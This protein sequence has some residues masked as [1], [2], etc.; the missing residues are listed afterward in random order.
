MWEEEE[1]LAPAVDGMAG[2][3]DRQHRVEGDGDVLVASVG[4]VTKEDNIE[5]E[6]YNS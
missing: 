1:V 4:V 6:L 5:L 2:G 3:V